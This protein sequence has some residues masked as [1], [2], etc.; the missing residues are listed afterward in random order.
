MSDTCTVVAILTKPNDNQLSS[1]FHKLEKSFMFYSIATS[2]LCPLNAIIYYNC[3][4]HFAF[5]V[6]YLYVL[7]FVLF[8]CRLPGLK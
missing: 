3:I 4:I 8:Y 5:S 2:S 7:R 1:C 6:C